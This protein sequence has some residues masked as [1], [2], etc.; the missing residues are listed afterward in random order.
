M[1]NFRQSSGRLSYF[2]SV[3]PWCWKGK[4]KP[5]C[6]VFFALTQF[7]FSFSA[8]QKSQTKLIVDLMLHLFHLIFAKYFGL[9]YNKYISFWRKTSK[10]RGLGKG[11]ACKIVV[12]GTGVSIDLMNMQYKLLLK[13]YAEQ[14]LAMLMVQKLYKRWQLPIAAG[15]MKVH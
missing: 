7:I 9:N 12:Y 13:Q 5:C 15:Y 1:D 2:I 11:W 3:L 6:W 4:C 8:K 10:E 14:E